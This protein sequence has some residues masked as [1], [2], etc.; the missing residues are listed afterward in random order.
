VLK[1]I[2]GKSVLWHVVD[3]LRRAKLLD[4]VIIATTTDP[5]DEA[6]QT[7]CRHENIDFFRGS[8]EDVLDRY[9]RAAN[10][11]KIDQI[12]RITSDCPLIDPEIVDQVIQKHL[13]SKADYSSNTLERTFPRGLDTEIC[14]YQALTRASK[15][16][17]DRAEREHVTLY[18]YRHPELFQLASVEAEGIF[19]R[20]D[21]RICVDT[22]EDLELIRRIYR[23]LKNRSMN[24]QDIVA[25]LTSKSELLQINAQVK[26]KAV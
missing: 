2:D 9:Y 23:E 19:R 11:F 4:Q 1:D 21:I 15:E 10:H 20:P 5:K 26:Q 12:V 8:E 25:L 16:V 13:A 18:F 6:I 3:R 7:F 14:T 22:L 17:K 24:C